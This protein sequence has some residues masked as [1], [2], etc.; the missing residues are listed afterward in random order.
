MRR[1]KVCDILY[2]VRPAVVAAQSRYRL[3]RLMSGTDL[4]T[5]P[6]SVQP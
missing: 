4:S 6:V 3:D 2:G 5:T 1:D